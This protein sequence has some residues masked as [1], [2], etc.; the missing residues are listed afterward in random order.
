MTSEAEIKK[1]STCSKSL[2]D[3]KY[4]EAIKLA[5]TLS[6]DAFRAG[7]FINGGFALGDSSKVRKGTK[8]FENMLLA[9]EIGKFSK[10]SILYN[11]ANGYSSLYE[12]KRKKGKSLDHLLNS[13]SSRVVETT[14]N[15][16]KIDIFSD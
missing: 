15:F 9:D 6:T 5:E 8:I 3:G 13:R 16:K 4:V 2:D 7:I 14:I 10:C 1:Y 12:L 11:T